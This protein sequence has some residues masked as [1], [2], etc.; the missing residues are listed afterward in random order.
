MSAGRLPVTRSSRCSACVSNDPAIKMMPRSSASNPDPVDG[1][2]E[3]LLSTGGHETGHGL[4]EAPKWV[5]AEPAKASNAEACLKERIRRT[6]PRIAYHVRLRPNENHLFGHADRPGTP[7]VLRGGA[8]GTPSWAHFW[9]PS[10]ECLAQA[11]LPTAKALG[12]SPSRMSASNLEI[13]APLGVQVFRRRHLRSTE[14]ISASSTSGS[15]DHTSTHAPDA[16]R[17]ATSVS[18][19]QVHGSPAEAPT[20]YIA[21][22]SGS[23]RGGPATER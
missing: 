3:I 8:R 20:D 19:K 23:G 6:L 14:V 10:I 22:S 18:P 17:A 9:H 21:E 11:S 5:L 12:L 1:R 16:A 2:E 7:R 13:G 4:F 15:S